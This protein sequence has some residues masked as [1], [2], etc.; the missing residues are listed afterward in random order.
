MSIVYL[1]ER[2]CYRLR[3]FRSVLFPVVDEALWNEAMLH[4]LPRW[5]RPLQKLR[6]SER[7]HILRLYRAITTDPD[8]TENERKTL[9]EL[10]LM[11]DVGKICTRPSILTR[12]VMTL[13]PIPKNAHPT[14]GARIL[15][16]LGANATLCRRVRGHHRD[17]GDDKL[18]AKFQQFDDSL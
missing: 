4:L 5:R 10:A 16:K 8:L 9:L 7:A 13:L 11:H 17:P 6:D 1:W 12:I 18:L 15:R 14:L 2:T 3:Q